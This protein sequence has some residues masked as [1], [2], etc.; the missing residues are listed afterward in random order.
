MISVLSFYHFYIYIQTI[1]LTC[2]VH[3]SD[4]E[5]N[6]LFVFSVEKLIFGDDASFNIQ[7]YKL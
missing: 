6:V 7:S 4:P 2:R 1:Y 3:Q 5:V